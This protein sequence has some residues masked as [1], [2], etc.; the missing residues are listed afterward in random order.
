LK[1]LVRIGMPMHTAMVAVMKCVRDTNGREPSQS[2]LA[3][4]LASYF[5][6][7]EI[8]NQLKY[9][10]KKTRGFQNEMPT[11]PP[12]TFWTFN[13]RSGPTENS[14]ARA[15]YFIPG[16]LEAIHKNIDHAEA[17]LGERPQEVELAACL[18]S[19]F[20]LSELKNQLEWLRQHH[21]EQPAPGFEEKSG[22]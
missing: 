12:P 14:L 9:Q 18:Q 4:A 7:N 13:L 22:E 2:E 17:L 19:S 5:M 6:I 20:I 21:P 3:Q 8:A 1:K 16:L 10:R 15:G 11:R